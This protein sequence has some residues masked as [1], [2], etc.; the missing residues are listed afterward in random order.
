MLM[1]SFNNRQ[2]NKSEFEMNMLEESIFFL[3]KLSKNQIKFLFVKKNVGRY[4]YTKANL[5]GV[6]IFPQKLIFKSVLI[7]S[8]FDY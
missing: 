6:N 5:E 8:E 3:Y 1:I 7:S 4:A 2:I